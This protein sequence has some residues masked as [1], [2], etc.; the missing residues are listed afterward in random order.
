VGD[1]GVEVDMLTTARETGLAE[2]TIPC[3]F[4]VQVEHGGRIVASQAVTSV[5]RV[6]EIGFNHTQQ[7]DAGVNFHL[8]PED[9]THGGAGSLGC[10]EQHHWVR[11]CPS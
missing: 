11:R 2:E 4:W 9:E 7:Y 6:S 3:D 5:R 1:Y 10:E 8:T